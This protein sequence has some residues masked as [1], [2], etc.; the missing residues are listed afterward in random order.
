MS[1]SRA[2]ADLILVDAD[3][4][5]LGYLDKARCH[6]G[7]G[8][9]H[10]AFSVFLYDASGRTLLQQRGRQKRLW[11]GYWSNSCCSHPRRGERT[12]AA[13]RRRVKEELGVSAPALRFAYKF[14]YHAR[15]RNSGAEHELCYVYV[16]RLGPRAIAR[17]A[18]DPSEITALKWLSRAAIDAKVDSP[19]SRV[20]PWLRLEW[21]TLPRPD[22]W[23]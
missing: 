20:T 23:P 7:A 12:L 22:I 6:D 4:R 3:D 13:A 5:V 11:P 15:Y 10:R 1:A 19:R 18:P 2:R 16:G 17:L 21:R 14:I 8:K 9:L